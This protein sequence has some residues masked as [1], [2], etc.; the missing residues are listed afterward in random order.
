MGAKKGKGS[1]NLRRI[2]QVKKNMHQW[3]ELH[4]NIKESGMPDV[5][6]VTSEIV[7]ATEEIKGI[8]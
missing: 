1:A 2:N 7:M 4:K 3:D 8:K 6:F 5:N